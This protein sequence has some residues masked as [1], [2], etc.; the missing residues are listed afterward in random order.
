M[1][2]GIEDQPLFYFCSETFDEAQNVDGAVTMEMLETQIIYSRDCF[3]RV[4]D[5][6]AQTVQVCCVALS[7]SLKLFR[8]F[9]LDY[10]CS[11]TQ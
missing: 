5:F 10:L 7:L 9:S 11:L 4:S 1:P 3:T 6:F 2:G 8:L